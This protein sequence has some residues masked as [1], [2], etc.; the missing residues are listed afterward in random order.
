MEIIVRRCG[1]DGVGDSNV[2]LA[3]GPCVLFLIRGYAWLLLGPVGQ[4]HLT[5]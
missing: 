3:L 1:N 5:K 2:M 4:P